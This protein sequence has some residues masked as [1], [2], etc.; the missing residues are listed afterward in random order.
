MIYF[1]V[2]FEVTMRKL[3]ALTILFSM[4]VL[5]LSGCLDE[6][7]ADDGGGDGSD[8]SFAMA[9][10]RCRRPYGRCINLSLMTIL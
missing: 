1:I 8:G 2:G 10:C 5:P 6:Q 3:T 4:L 7:D 9:R